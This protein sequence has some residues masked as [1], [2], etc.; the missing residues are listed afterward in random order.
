M[1][2]EQKAIARLREKLAPENFDD[3]FRPVRNLREGP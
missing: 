1:V 3:G 2:S